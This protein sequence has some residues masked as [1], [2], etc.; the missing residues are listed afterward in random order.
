MKQVVEAG[1]LETLVGLVGDEH[2]KCDIRSDKQCDL[3]EEDEWQI[4]LQHGAIREGKQALDRG[5]K[6]AKRRAELLGALEALRNW[7]LELL[8]TANFNHSDCDWASDTD[9]RAERY[10]EGKA[11]QH[12]VFRS[13]QEAVR[14]AEQAIVNAKGVRDEQMS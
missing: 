3:L 6:M 14:I 4:K 2:Y 1:L 11:E 7:T 12:Q 10:D 8:I 5:F 9:C 13:A